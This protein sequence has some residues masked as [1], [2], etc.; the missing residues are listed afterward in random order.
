MKITHI[1]LTVICLTLFFGGC[2]GNSYY[3]ETVFKE[4]PDFMVVEMKTYDPLSEYFTFKYQP[5]VWEIEEWPVEEAPGVVVLVNKGYEDRSC[6]L[7]P[8][9]IGT[10][11]EEGQYVSAGTLLTTKGQASML[12]IYNAAGIHLKEIVGYEVNGIPYV[13]EV[14]LP[15]SQADQCSQDAQLVNA[16]FEVPGAFEEPETT[17]ESPPTAQ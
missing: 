9:S 13:F 11:G 3:T 15:A 4:S 14:N 5:S 2:L 7:L 17:E 6:Y 12:D 8:G 16:T 1:V 10:G